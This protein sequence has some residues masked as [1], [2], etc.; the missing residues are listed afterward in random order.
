MR[1]PAGT[2]CRFYYEDYYRGREQ[3]ECRLIADT[4]GGGRW[5]PKLC[6]RCPV[7]SLL[8]ANASP[9]LALQARAAR[10][11]FFWRRVQ[12]EAY[13][14]KHLVEIEDLYIGCGQ[15]NQERAGRS[16]IGLPVSDDDPARRP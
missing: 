7:P 14:T 8:R 5:E 13:C 1:T 3:R 6:A 15:C 11:L 4:P 10:R 9:Y 2:E 12:V 16:A